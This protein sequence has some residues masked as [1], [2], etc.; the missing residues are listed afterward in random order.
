MV[1][2]QYFL[3]SGKLELE[4]DFSEDSEYISHLEPWQRLTPLANENGDWYQSMKDN[5]V[6]FNV[7]V[8]RLFQTVTA[9]ITFQNN[10]VP[11]VEIGA[12]ADSAGNYLSTPIQ[13]RVIDDLDWYRINTDGTSLYQREAKYA[14]VNDFISGF[15]DDM[16]VG[17]Y[18]YDLK[19]VIEHGQDRENIVSFGSDS[20]IDAVDYIITKYNEP[21]VKGEWLVNSASFDIGRLLKDKSNNLRF[22]ISAP[23]LNA[24][25]AAIKISKIKIIYQKPPITV[26]NV[27]PKIK[28]KVNNILSQD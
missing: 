23:G 18:Y 4:Y 25:N 26:S 13:N 11:V 12:R 5:L 10:S 1:F 9:E 7:K 6:Y 15:R 2:N 24:S 17:E 20:D 21:F 28:N 22:R 14:S 8:P 16:T 19:K 3:P 27:W